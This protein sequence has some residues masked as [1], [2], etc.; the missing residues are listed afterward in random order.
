MEILRLNQYAISNLNKLFKLIAGLTASYFFYK[1]GKFY[2][3][4]RKYR[5]IP[6]PATNGYFLNYI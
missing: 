6:G 2:L 1:V 4:K 5:H 3:F